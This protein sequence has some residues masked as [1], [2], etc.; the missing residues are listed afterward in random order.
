MENPGTSKAIHPKIRELIT[1]TML[2]CG[3]AIQ[4]ISAYKLSPAELGAIREVISVAIKT[5][6]YRGLIAQE[7]RHEQLL[8]PWDPDNET[9]EKYLRTRNHPEPGSLWDALKRRA[10]HR[11]ASKRSGPGT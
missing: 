1:F 7:E 3:L 11:Y 10:S 8:E 5:A 6:F 4:R 2:Q 9:T